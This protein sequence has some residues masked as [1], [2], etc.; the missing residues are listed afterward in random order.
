MEATIEDRTDG[1]K[2]SVAHAPLIATRLKS[3]KSIH[4][5]N[6]YIRRAAKAVRIP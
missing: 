4:R 1:D 6:K 5:R 2:W 3:S